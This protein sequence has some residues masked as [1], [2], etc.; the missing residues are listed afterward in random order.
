MQMEA[1]FP[2]PLADARARA[3]CI[4]TAKGETVGV[5]RVKELQQR[6][7]RSMIKPRASPHMQLYQV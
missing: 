7:K 6:A 1:L 5:P 2:L 4:R 3:H